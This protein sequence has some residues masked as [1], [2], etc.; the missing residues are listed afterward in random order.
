M[1]E[2][3][4]EVVNVFERKMKEKHLF[5]S[6]MLTFSPNLAFFPRTRTKCWRRKSIFNC[7]IA[8]FPSDS[9][10]LHRI[11]NTVTVRCC[12]FPVRSSNELIQRRPSLREMVGPTT[13][14]LPRT[15][16]FLSLMSGNF[17]PVAP[18]WR[19][20]HRINQGL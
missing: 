5:L 17:C 14:D 2:I 19:Q 7:K 1:Q 18:F 9:W 10:S 12:H 16:Q 13:S 3:P 20:I 4:R 15:E 6:E 8:A 11:A